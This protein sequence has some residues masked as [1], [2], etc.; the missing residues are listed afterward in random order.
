M[1]LDEVKLQF[2]QSW[3]YWGANG[4]LTELLLTYKL[5]AVM[6]ICKSVN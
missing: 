4:L 2:I 3:L 5:V 6:L 1:K